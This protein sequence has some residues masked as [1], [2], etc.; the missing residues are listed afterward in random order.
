M[1]GLA[2]SY[3]PTGSPL[4]AAR[5]SVA[6]AYLTVPALVAAWFEHP[7]VL[8]ATLIG[9]VAAGVGAGVA[10]GTGVANRMAAPPE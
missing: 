5:T 1:I 3:R 2:P 7:L 10:V 9:T 6:I 4:H 8:A